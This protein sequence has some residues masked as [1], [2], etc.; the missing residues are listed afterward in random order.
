MFGNI[1]KKRKKLKKIEKTVDKKD[2]HVVFYRSA[3]GT[4]PTRV[5][6]GKGA[7][8]L[9][10]IQSRLKETTVNSEMSFNL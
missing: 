8:I 6:V 9:K 10:T 4:E 3:Q 5:G 7:G 1:E 2:D